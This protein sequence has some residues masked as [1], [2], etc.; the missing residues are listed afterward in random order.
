MTVTLKHTLTGVVA[1]Y[2]D[3]YLDH[4]VWGSVLVPTHEEAFCT[5]C[6][7]PT[8]PIEPEPEPEPEIEP[9]IERSGN[10]EFT[11][12]ATPRKGRRR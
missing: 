7:I 6:E 2:P 8:P 5:D 10:I 12:E 4:P 11:V 9:E 3:E 1:E